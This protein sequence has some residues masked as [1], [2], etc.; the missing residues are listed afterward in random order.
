M[1]ADGQ[2]ISDL[3]AGPP[4]QTS[5]DPDS[6]TVQGGDTVSMTPASPAPADLQNMYTAAVQRMPALR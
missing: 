1:N 5:T 4:G 2:H 3:A 6:Q